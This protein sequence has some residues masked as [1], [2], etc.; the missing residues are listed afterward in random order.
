M[1]QGELKKDIAFFLK[2]YAIWIAIAIAIIIAIT[3][4]AIIVINK[5]KKIDQIDKTDNDTWLASLGGKEN[6]IEVSAT[7]SR[8]SI[9]L[10]DLSLIDEAKLKENGVTSILKMSNK[11]TLVVEDKADKILAKIK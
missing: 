7:G 10:N 3:L 6:I 8:L 11:I 5:K 4:V 2:T 9:K 1:G